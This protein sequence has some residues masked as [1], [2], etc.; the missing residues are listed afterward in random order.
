M[1]IFRSF[2]GMVH[3]EIT[4]AD[5]SGFL[6][7]ISGENILVEQMTAVD[8]MRVHGTVLH[9]DLKRIS[10]L[11]QK[12]GAQ[13]EV[14]KKEGLYWSV[15]H[16]MRRPVLMTGLSMLLL[17]SL[18]LPTRI[19]FVQVEGNAEVPSKLIL[20]VADECGISL[21]SSRR[22]VRSEKVKNALLE[23][24]PG[25][26]WVGVN[27]AGCVATISVTEKSITEGSERSQTGVC[28]IVASRDGVIRECTVVRGNALCQV[29]QA[30]KAGQTLISGYTDCG[31]AIKGTRAEAEVYAQTLRELQV[32]TPINSVK[33]GLQTGEE[34]KYSLIFGKNL[35]KFYKGSGIS[36][37]SC[38][39]IY[40]EIKL[41]LPGGFQ[42]PVSLIRETYTYHENTEADQG[43]YDWMATASER[44]LNSQ[45]VAGQI[46]D[47]M[48]QIDMLDGICC[49]NG[50]YSCLEMIGQIKNEEILQR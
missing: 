36:D 8:E 45:M 23:K 28:S 40:E 37:A 42:L 49:L 26:Q 15:K 21:F 35:I 1:G 14:L 12:R 20:E 33:R 27:T 48:V 25:L 44:Y 3:V 17:F 31:I 22:A 39:K 46:L 13:V 43:D 7:L 18:Y 11:A 16:F 50:S 2:S 34:T 41:T 19:L 6:S 32:I 5:V 47:Q 30:V 38:V 4:S 9:K 29:G 10:A 24:V